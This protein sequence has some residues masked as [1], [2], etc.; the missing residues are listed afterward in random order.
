MRLPA[1]T[2]P[3]LIVSL[4][5]RHLSPITASETA[6]YIMQIIRL[7]TNRSGAVAPEELAAVSN[8]QDRTGIFRPPSF[9]L[10]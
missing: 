4:P 8:E 9:S 2:P 6:E 1:S 3:G 7:E 10:Y 5:E